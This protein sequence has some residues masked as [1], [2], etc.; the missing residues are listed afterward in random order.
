MSDNSCWL[1]DLQSR[2][3]QTRVS[4]RVRYWRSV[5]LR[6]WCVSVQ[7]LSCASAG[8]RWLA[9]HPA[10]WAPWYVP[11][12]THPTVETPTRLIPANYN[13]NVMSHTVKPILSLGFQRWGGYSWLT[14]GAWCNTQHSMT[15]ILSP[16]HSQ[17]WWEGKTSARKFVCQF[18]TSTLFPL[19]YTN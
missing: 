1:Q 3:K 16:S 13:L 10:E 2:R 17:R 7:C 9:A 14:C 12:T 5:W 19:F 4:D 15:S 11:P 8:R 6:M 18:Y